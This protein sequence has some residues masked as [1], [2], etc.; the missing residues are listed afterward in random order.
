MIIQPIHSGCSSL[1]IP[2]VSV[3]R[4]ITKPMKPSTIR[5]WKNLSWRSRWMK[6]RLCMSVLPTPTPKN[7]VP[8]FSM[9][10]SAVRF[11]AAWH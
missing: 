3:F 7:C 4:Q 5:A 6:A 2:M 10:T 11:H 9:T 8:A 1:L